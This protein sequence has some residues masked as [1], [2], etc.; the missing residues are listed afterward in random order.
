MRKFLTASSIFLMACTGFAQEQQNA[1]L[2]IKDNPVV[3]DFNFY[4][5]TRYD[6]NTKFGPH[7]DNTS[8]FQVNKTRIYLTTKIKDKFQV[9]LRYNLNAAADAKALEFAFLEYN[10][11][12]NWAISAGQLITAWGTFEIDY[13]GADIYNNTT[14]LDNLE[15]YAPG[16]NLAYMFK[17]HRFNLQITSASSQYA[18]PE[19]VNKAY[20]Y[21]FLWQG[22]FFQDKLST[23]YG[24]G[25]MQHDS[26]KYYNWITLGNQLRIDRWFAELDW[27]YGFRNINFDPTSTLTGP[28]YDPTYVKENAV[29]LSVK[30]HFDNWNPYIKAIYNKRDALDQ[31]AAFSLLSLQGAFEYYPFKKDPLFKD[32]R[33]FAAYTYNLTTYKK[34]VANLADINQH[35]VLAGVR[36]LIPIAKSAV[37]DSNYKT[38]IEP[39]L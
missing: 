28:L 1:F 35:Q 37:Q 36:W 22:S 27:I 23:R 8:G 3:S 12:D 24:Y 26:S 18:T 16:V 13:N 7:Y 15:V 9:F 21:M 34:Q 6:L 39:Y 14:L 17:N 4:L 30:Y 19:Y 20:A 31:D 29:A 5:D 10:I 32:I 25:L 33:L 11:N 38:E 2:T